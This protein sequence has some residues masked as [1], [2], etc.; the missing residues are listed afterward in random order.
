MAS[1]DISSVYYL[2]GV[3][4][5]PDFVFV[6]TQLTSLDPRE[7][8]HTRCST[9]NPAE[10]DV[11]FGYFDLEDNIV[12]V[13]AYRQLPEDK[14]RFACV[15][16]QGAVHFVRGSTREVRTERLPGA[17]LVEGNFGGLMMNLRDIGGQLW[18]C[19]QHG[20]VYRR[21]GVDDWRRADEG[22]RVTID[23][24]EYGPDRIDEMLS[25][26]SSAPM[27]NCIDGT[28][29]ADVYVVG[30]QGFLAHFDGATWR[31]IELPVSE[32]LDWVRCADDEVWICGHRGTLLRGNA[33]SGFVRVSGGDDQHTFVCLAKF[34][35]AVYLSA[36]EGLFVYDGVSVLPVTS[37]LKPEIQDAWRLDHAD[38]VMWSIGVTDLVRFDGKTWTRVHH[39]DNEPIGE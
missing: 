12:S 32:H 19:G 38:G 34:N 28:S 1:E 4:V 15:G 8:A 5:A 21:F 31:K 11:P 6:A 33:R 16:S 25:V 9:Y 7:T 30:M 36:E 20:Q 3:V 27:L 22:I 2:D 13:H 24:A 35:D 29:N 18:A 37:K 23:P 39:P 17:G 10:Q 14:K 26:M